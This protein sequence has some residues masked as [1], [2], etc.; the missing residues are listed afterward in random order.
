MGA[1]LRAGWARA[2]G[3]GQGPLQS[4]GW[5]LGSPLSAR[6]QGGHH[7]AAHADTAE[8]PAALLPGRPGEELQ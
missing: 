8:G 2:G 1:R 4:M 7:H 3:I 5:S 6:L